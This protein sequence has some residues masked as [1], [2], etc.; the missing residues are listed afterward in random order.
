MRF[1]ASQRDPLPIGAPA[2]ERRVIIFDLASEGGS[3]WHG[4]TQLGQHWERVA[5]GRPAV[6][7]AYSPVGLV[8]F[9][10]TRKMMLGIKERAE[11]SRDDPDDAPQPS[12]E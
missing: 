7:F 11:R 8:S 4:Q 9:V 12:G 3:S 2:R 5:F 10:M 6:R 1:V